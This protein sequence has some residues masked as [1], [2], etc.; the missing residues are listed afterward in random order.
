MTGRIPLKG[1]VDRPILEVVGV[2]AGS[3]D[4]VDM[5]HLCGTFKAEY[6][7]FGFNCQWLNGHAID[8]HAPSRKAGTLHCHNLPVDIAKRDG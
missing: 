1:E 5:R 6:I 2:R 3:A 4:S 8:R 7:R